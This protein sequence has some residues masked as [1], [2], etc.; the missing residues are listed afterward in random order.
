MPIPEEL[1][2]P[3]L[4]QQ[5]NIAFD[6]AD[7]DGSGT[8]D[9]D[10]LETLKTALDIKDDQFDVLIGWIKHFDRDGNGKF[11]REELLEIVVIFT[12]FTMLP[13][14]A[15]KGDMEHFDALADMLF[16]ILDA[17]HSGSLDKDEISF[18]LTTMSSCIGETPDEMFACIDRDSSGMVD[19]SEFLDLMRVLLGPSV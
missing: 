8:I 11:D 5:V 12:I 17:D 13:E 16:S 2:D 1:K 15:E 19:R 14:L 6:E 9:V 3:E 10:E 4:I 18:L 7:T